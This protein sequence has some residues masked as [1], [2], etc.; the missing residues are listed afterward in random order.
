MK[1]LDKDQTRLLIDNVDEFTK[2]LKTD[3]RT[4]PELVHCIP[5]YIL[6]WDDVP[7]LLLG[8]MLPKTRA[9][10]ESQDKIGWRIF[11]KGYISPHFFA[12]QQHHLA[13]ASSYLNG[14]DWRIQFV[15]KILQITHSQWIYRNIS[16]HD[17]W[18]GYLHHKMAEEILQQRSKLSDLASDKVLENSH[19]LLEISFTELTRTNL[20]TQRYWTLAVN[21]K[22]KTQSL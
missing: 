12:I 15:S 22:L 7:F 4:D 8:W 16:L 13:I 10:A 1:C 19:F 18:Q 17:K 21:A 11:T 2:W 14:A 3:G 20:E 9:L 5:K 6:M